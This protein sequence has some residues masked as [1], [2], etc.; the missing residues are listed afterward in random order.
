MLE[1]FGHR[2]AQ[3]LGGR[4]GLAVQVMR[5]HLQHRR[6]LEDVLARQHEVAN[7]AEGVEIA[8]RVHGLRGSQRLGAHVLRR[9][10]HRARIRELGLSFVAQLL[11]EAKVEKLGH[12]GF[13]T[14]GTQNHVR[15]LDV[16]VDELDAVGLFQGAGQLDQHLDHASRRLRS[17]DAHDVLER[18][19]VE[20]FHGVVEEPIWSPPVV[21]D[22][23]GVRVREPSRELHLALESGEA[24]LPGLLRTH[25]LDGCGAPHHGVARPV[26][27]PHAPLAELRLQRVLP[28]S[29]RL[30]NLSA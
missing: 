2:L 19:S 14:L 8:A 5:T 11:D 13:A 16:S 12:V 3:A 30:A 17:I 29:S 9:A 15:R 27:R 1:I 20:Q 25:E 10:S 7:S 26:D 22:G 6:A 28:E 24:R 4:F 18:C 21:E 23:D